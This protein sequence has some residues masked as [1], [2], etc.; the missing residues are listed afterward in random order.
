MLP[1]KINPR[2]MQRMMKRMGISMNEVNAEQV[3]IKCAD[4]EIVIDNPQVVVTKVQGQDMYQISGDVREQ[5]SGGEVRL[6]ISQDD[7]KMVAE[8]AKVPEK[9]AR[10]ALEKAGGDIAQAIMD[11]KS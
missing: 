7:V 11:L 9:K 5:S 4:R 8:Q 6:E 1:G 2:Q 3:V 10:D